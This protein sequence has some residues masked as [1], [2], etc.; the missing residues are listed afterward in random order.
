MVTEQQA[1]EN[2]GVGPSHFDYKQST[3]HDLPLNDAS[4]LDDVR[5]SIVVDEATTKDTH[6]DDVLAE[7][8]MKSVTEL[9][10]QMSNDFQEQF[11]SKYTPRIFPWALLYDCG[12]AEYP[13]LYAN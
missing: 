2:S 5:P 9:T 3:M 8:A 6:D 12:G 13:E 11:V 10:I 7:Q 4:V 1:R